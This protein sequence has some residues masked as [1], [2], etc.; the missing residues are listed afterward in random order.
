MRWVIIAAVVL[1]VVVV[2]V[3]GVLAIGWSLPVKHRATRSA[4]IAA[5]PADVFA[6]IDA[7]AGF[8]QWRSGV[9][10]VE[11]VTT[12]DAGAPLSFREHS[13]DGAI[14]YDIVERV[15]DRRLVT[16]IADAGLPFGGQWTYELE[17]DGDGTTLRI[18]EDGEVYNPLFRFVSRF[19]MGHTASIDRYLG[20]VTRRFAS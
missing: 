1:V 7:P 11:V 8:A 14:T 20:D 12:D 4:R 5:R 9:T 15:R 6:L 16:R 17:P 13:G 19:V 3:V 18:T 10:R 2:L